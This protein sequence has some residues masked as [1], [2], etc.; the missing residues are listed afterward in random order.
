MRD[1]LPA[2]GV[3]DATLLWKWVRYYVNNWRLSGSATE[4]VL[5]ALAQ[6]YWQGVISWNEFLRCDR[7]LNTSA[8]ESHPVKPATDLTL[9]LSH[10]GKVI[11]GQYKIVDIR[12]FVDQGIIFQAQNGEQNVSLLCLTT[13]ADTTDE[14]IRRIPEMNHYAGHSVV[15][16]PSMIKTA[17]HIYLLLP[18][19][20]GQPLSLWLTAH[21]PTGLPA[22][23]ANI[24]LSSIYQL[25]L[26]LRHT[27][28]LTESLHPG[29]LF[30]D[31]DTL[32][33]QLVPCLAQMHYELHPNMRGRLYQAPGL[34]VV[35]K[36]EADLGY[37]LLAIAYELFT[38]CVPSEQHC[39]ADV[40]K[41][42]PNLRQW[43]KKQIEQC[44]SAEHPVSLAKAALILDANKKYVIRDTTLLALVSVFAV[45]AFVWQG[46]N[47]LPLWMGPTA[48]TDQTIVIKQTDGVKDQHVNLLKAAFF[49][50][51]QENNFS[52]AKVSWQ[53]LSKILPQDDIFIEKIGP[54]LMA[55]HQEAMQQQPSAPI[56]LAKTDAVP[57]S[58]VIPPQKASLDITGLSPIPDAIAALPPLPDVVAQLET[59]VHADPC[60]QA[61]AKEGESTSLCIDALS[62]TKFGPRLVAIRQQDKP[63]VI[64]Q[65]VVSIADYNQ[66]CAMTSTCSAASTGAGLDFE[67]NEVESTVH[68]YNSYCL[69][70]GLCEPLDVPVQPVFLPP[71]QIQNYA[72]WLS[73]ETGYSYRVPTRHEWQEMNRI[74]G[75]AQEGAQWVMDHNGQWITTQEDAAQSRVAFHLVR[76]IK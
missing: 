56:E 41:A 53:A 35:K 40:L 38:G 23:L 25:I 74:L 20:T 11:G 66:Y 27:S 12:G 47:Y 50:Q 31:P 73:S 33:L 76:E 67:L 14:I 1:F 10:I 61:L 37:R 42:C 4:S 75:H 62:D 54:E 71:K 34:S 17:Q 59:L 51:I 7:L 6:S 5:G 2:Q 48:P 36:K 60:M 29:Q 43:Q 70:S 69:V 45:A 68:D 58:E 65:Q 22:P 9:A 13:D 19:L 32:N 46:I 49:T 64:T 18:T 16:V 39:M 30:I 28:E 63:W 52:G 21:F 57:T 55:L 72:N 15:K 24:L 8:T 3:V 26:K 44:L